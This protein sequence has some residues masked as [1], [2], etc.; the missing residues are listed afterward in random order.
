MLISYGSS[1]VCSS[2]L[3]TRAPEGFSD[4]AIAT[5][6]RLSP[7]L[8]LAL[9]CQALHGIST[10]IAGTYLGRNAATQVMQGS[11]LRGVASE[12]EAV[13]WSSDLMGFKIG[14]AHV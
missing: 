9:K 2:D 4:A 5:I 10:T 12:I 7:V 1:D 3:M 6:R 8:A 13:L 11:I 14:R